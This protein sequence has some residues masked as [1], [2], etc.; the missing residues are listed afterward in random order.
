MLISI[1]DYGVGN[2]TSV[3]NMFR[4][5]GADARICKDLKEIE[6]ASKIVLP[7][8]GAFDNCMQKYN[9]SGFRQAIEQR[10][11]QDKVP[12][13]GICVGLQ[14]MMEN[15]EEGD[16]RGL[17][18]VQG[19]TV[20]FDKA[21][22]TAE[23]KIPNMGWLD[24]TFNKGSKLAS[25]LDDARFYFAHSFH[26]RPADEKDTLITASYGYA[27]A[28]GIEKNNILGVQFHPEKSHR[29][30]MQLF[31]NFAANY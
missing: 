7:G 30:G 12:V 10:V 18:W 27:F 21:Q 5:A 9:E 16:L 23:Q 17:G 2:L 1:I 11:L 15:S 31:K 3:Q 14:M 26:V 22:M 19:K 4:K 8:M 29:F 28:A 20:A 24:I 25:G 13:L 6:S